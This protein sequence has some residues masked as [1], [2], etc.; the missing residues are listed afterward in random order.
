MLFLPTVLFCQIAESDKTK[1]YELGISYSPDYSFRTLKPEA[2]AKWIAEI[3]DSLEIP[4]LGY[5]A[6]L[7]LVSNFHKKFSI[8]TGL[9]LSD[10]GERTK[11]YSSKNIVA[12]NSPSDIT[13]INRYYYLTIPVKVNYY[14]LTQKIKLYVTAGVSTNIFINQ[15]TIMLLEYSD[16]STERNKYKVKSEFKTLN[17]DVVVGV[18]LDYELTEKFNFKLEP[19]YK[20]SIISVINAPIKTYLYSTGINI[21]IYYKL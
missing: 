15:Q 19:L 20:R 1:K 6:G 10:K 17:F 13:L 3:R 7:N 12:G 18:G 5:T 14:I 16:G 11:K 4:K 21:G 9:L 2:A 8:A